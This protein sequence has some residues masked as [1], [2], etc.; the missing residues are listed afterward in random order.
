MELMRILWSRCLA[1]FYRSKLD[2]DLDEELRTHI[3]LAIAE[4]LQR[5]M[6]H[7]DARTA[8]FR[9]FGGVTQTKEHYRAQGGLPLLEVLAQDVRF[10]FRQ[11]RRSPGFT[12]VC[13][14]TLCLGM[15]INT[16]VFSIIQAVLLRPPPYLDPNRLVLLADP[17][18]PQDGGILYKDF[19]SWKL[20]SHS[21]SDMAVYYRDSGWS[22]VMIMD[23]QE[24]EA[25]QGAF[26]SANFF[27]LLGVPPVLGRGFT[28]EEESRHERVAVLSYG[29]W[30]RRFGGSPDV[31]GQ[32]IRIDGESSQIIGVMPANFRFPAGDSQLWAPITTNRYWGDTALNSHDAQH[33]RG[34]YA[35]WQAIGRLKDRP[36]PQEAQAELNS[37]FRALERADPDPD[38]GSG[39]KVLPLRVQVNGNIRLALYILF[40]SV[41]LLLLIACSNVANLILARGFSRTSEMALRTAL[42]ATRVRILQ[43]LLTEAVVLG[44][45]GGLFSLPVAFLGIRGLVAL[46]PP[47]IPRLQET[48]LN[49]G[50]LGFTFAVALLCAVI[51]G[52]APALRVWRSDPI[53]QIKSRSAAAS[54]PGGSMSFRRFL[55]VSEFALAVVLLTAAGLLIRSFLIVRAVDPGFEAEHVL[56]VNVS[57]PG[58]SSG[59]PS[60][61]FDSLVARLQAVPGVKDAGAID[62]LFDLGSTQNL[63]LR[64]IEGHTPERREQWT[65]L[66]WDTVR[67]DYFQ[68][69]GAQ[70]LRG[71]YFS[72]EDGPQSPLVAIIDESAARRYWPGENPVGKR[73]K[74][75][76]RRGQNDDWLTVVGVV[77]DIR[78]HGL[79]RQ[80]TPHIY[81]WSRQSGNATADVLVR[82]AGDPRAFAGTL[83][84]VVRSV[85]PMATLSNVTTVQQ[86]LSQQLLA[87]RFQTLL[88]GLFCCLP[89]HWRLSESSD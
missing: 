52:L 57:L 70:L 73:F 46:G 56:R 25:I 11:L 51:F 88:L 35:R 24:P 60:S 31:V 27:P 16:A 6:S 78:T 77:H 63:G 53:E 79:E 19:Q 9:D 41:C 34:F 82:V 50:V 85:A 66:T 22:R 12:L 39:I 74:G 14:V 71:R 69:L 10:G 81:E 58:G 61:L 15:G 44:A 1:L 13:L 55:I 32:K 5:G 67:G 76:D 17:Q 65:A 54:D 38:R 42:G 2:E 4:K 89:S 80:P 45:L 84:D 26:V 3:D 37:L 83:R 62:S 48:G 40:G 75:Q 87:R 59:W 49:L 21:F 30:Q 28:P 8:A 20:H 68:T 33:S 23:S 86:Q 72:D 29:L 64:S 7:Q 43:Q 36:P 47:T 18:D